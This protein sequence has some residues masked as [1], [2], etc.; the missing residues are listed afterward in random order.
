MAD[1]KALQEVRDLLGG[2]MMTPAIVVGKQVLIGFAA[3]RAQMEELFPR[4]E[5]PGGQT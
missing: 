4:R 3:N 5:A 1:G 2:R